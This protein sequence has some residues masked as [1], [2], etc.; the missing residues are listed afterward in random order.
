MS[1]D[2]GTDW[3]WSPD[4]HRWHNAATGE[5][6]GVAGALDRA[7]A[8]LMMAEM[9]LRNHRAFEDA[10]IVERLRLDFGE[11]LDAVRQTEP[12]DASDA[13]FWADVHREADAEDAAFLA[14]GKSGTDGPSPP[15]P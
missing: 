12:P 9:R 7:D 14:A 4:D 10:S 13:A 1:H 15:P 11:L 5:T 3:R 6:L 8:Y 2:I